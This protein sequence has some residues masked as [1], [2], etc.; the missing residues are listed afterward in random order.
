MSVYKTHDATYNL[1]TG[2][3]YIDKGDRLGDYKQIADGSYEFVGLGVEGGRYDKSLVL[4]PLYMA[5][6][7]SKAE[8]ENMRA[9]GTYGIREFHEDLD[10]WTGA[11]KQ[12]RGIQ[13]IATAVDIINYL[14][15]LFYKEPFSDVHFNPSYGQNNGLNGKCKSSFYNQEVWLAN[16]YGKEVATVQ[17]NQRSIVY[18]ETR[19]R[20][21]CIYYMCK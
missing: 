6:P 21:Y 12:C 5:P 14:F 3:R 9:S 8:C 17:F 7:I 20:H 10:T 4:I 13:N 16:E 2:C 19:P 1:K 11:F 15:P 18:P